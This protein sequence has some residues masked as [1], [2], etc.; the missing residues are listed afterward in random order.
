[1]KIFD[2]DYFERKGQPERSS[3]LP[4]L[5]PTAV[6]PSSRHRHQLARLIAAGA[7]AALLTLGL[8]GCAGA[9]S[10]SSTSST[11]SQAKSTASD[12]SA[13]TGATDGTVS[14]NIAV[15]TAQMDFGYTDR[16][17]DPSYA[18]GTAT[19]VELT[20]SSAT[21]T[22]SGASVDGS[23]VSITQ[24]GTYV[25]SGTLDAGQVVVAADDS[26]KV[27]LVLNGVS[28]TGGDG[29]CILIQS[30]DKVFISLADGT[31]NTL[32]DSAGWTL[33][34]E[35]G[36]ADAT[37]YSTSDLTFNGN[38]SLTVTATAESGIKSTDDLVV[39]GGAYVINAAKDGLRGKDCVKILNGSFT[40][41]ATEDGIKSSNDSDANRGF[42]AID[43]G[44]FTIDAGDDGIDA[45]RYVGITN[46]A[47]VITAADDGLHSDIDLAVTGGSTSINADDDA[48]HAE[49]NLLVSDGVI[50]A[51]SQ[52]EGL[53]AQGILISGGTVNLSCADDALNASA[54]D[55]ATSSSTGTGG[56][57]QQGP[58]GGMEAGSNGLE[59]L[60]ISGGTVT[61]V[62]TGDADG[63][64]S[65]GTLTMSG[66]SV[67]I[68]GANVNG[69][70][71]LD[72]GSSGQIT[73]GTVLAL[74]GSGMT[75]TFDST[76]TQ[77]S[78][79][80]TVSGPAGSVV[81]IV[82]QSGAVIAQMTAEN[83]FSWLTASDASLVEGETYTILVDGTEAATAS[84][85]TTQQASGMGDGQMPQQGGRGVGGRSPQQGGQVPQGSQPGSAPQ[86]GAN[87]SG[88]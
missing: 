83:S 82:S 33:S 64:D 24:E 49:Y 31:E 66:G 2:T 69:N 4:Q 46:G 45:V 21:V 42:V 22:G 50:Q 1:M 63:I 17:Q 72:Y 58:G 10:A 65:N 15:D 48:A 86:P 16:D 87:G 43:G 57:S 29:P 80:A 68:S 35:D 26:A 71:A 18:A 32:A 79:T 27:H 62:T 59:N 12:G 23:T 85:T 36:E 52:G 3:S 73:G 54:A 25:L 77:P 84:A 14:E 67:Y 76:S 44:A 78:V 70:R 30:A 88:A 41:T 75:Q 34:G 5:H 13:L 47:L 60:T 81:S 19:A 53:E 55:N 61:I 38:G 7:V 8:A 39:T 20:G 28:I 56:E 40:I 6:C 9:A 74:G 37:L 11:A 51:T